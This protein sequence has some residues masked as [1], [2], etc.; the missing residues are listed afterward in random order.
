MGKLLGEEVW[1]QGAYGTERHKWTTERTLNLASGVVKHRFLVLPNAPYNLM[2]RDLLHKLRAGIQFSEGGMTVTL[3]QPTV[4]VLM[5]AVDEYLL[6]EPVS[7][8]EETKGE[9]EPSP[10]P[11]G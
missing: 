5:A 11:T 4:Q 8:P 10:N 9:G 6:Y 7:K 2:R 1:V 3:R